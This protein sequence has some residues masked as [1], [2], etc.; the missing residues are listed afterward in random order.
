M[1][2]QNIYQQNNFQEIKKLI[3]ES[4]TCLLVT[5]LSSGNPQFGV[6]NPLVLEDKIFLHNSKSDEQITDLRRNPEC[7]LIFQDTLAILP[8]YWVDEKYA[9]V[10]TTYY[11]YAE[12]GCSARLIE[13]TDEQTLFYK[14]LMKHF[15]PEGNYDP[16]DYSSPIYK[17]KMDTIL[18]TQFT[19]D[20]IK[21]KWKLGQNRSVEKRIEIANRFR[22]RN[23][24]GDS[25]AAD[26]IER[27]IELNGGGS[28]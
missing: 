1:K 22:E 19:I 4:K 16:I 27:W 15:Q 12:L 9:G 11:R 25:R 6:F 28:Q 13:D 2:L 21:A 17:S 18:V 8:S 24:L 7:R 26:E 23:Q 20:S 3:S 14:N 10:A 5:G